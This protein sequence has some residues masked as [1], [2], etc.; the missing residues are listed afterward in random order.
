MQQLIEIA[1]RGGLPDQKAYTALIQRAREV[2]KSEDPLYRPRDERDRPGGL[3][4]LND[5]P[6][7]I[8]PDLHA[9]PWFLLHVLAHRPVLHRSEP[10]LDTTDNDTDGAHTDSGTEAEAQKPTEPENGGAAERP[11]VGELLQRGEIQ[12]ICVGDGFHAESRAAQRWKQAFKEFST[13]FRKHTAMDEE[14]RE[15]LGLMEIVMKLKIMRPDSFHFLKGNHENIM[16]EEGRGNHPFRKFAYE[17]EMVKEWVLKF[18]GEEFISEFAE[19]EHEFPLVAVDGTFMVSHAEPQRFFT[20]EEVIRYRE[21]DDVV[22]GLTWT[23]NDGAEEGSVE[24]M[25]SEYCSHPDAARYFGGHRP[26]QGSYNLRA[27][28]KYIQLHNPG[29]Y[30][31]ALVTPGITP[32]PQRDIIEIPY[33]EDAVLE[34]AETWQDIEEDYG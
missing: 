7:L 16:N 20:H 9:R 34:A 21:Y 28:D 23:P 2:L 18:Y 19:M 29:T 14:M 17:G 5:R 1:R 32:D 26:V 30:S 27:G 25:I 12:M 10:V 33:D 15:S 13:K 3:I 22:L 8:V 24:Q 6:T 4:R 11:T 31:F